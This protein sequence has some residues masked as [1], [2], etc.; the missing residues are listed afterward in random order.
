M[1]QPVGNYWIRVFTTTNRHDNASNQFN[2]VLQYEGASNT[3]DPDSVY[4]VGNRILDDSK[5]LVPDDISNLMIPLKSPPEFNITRAVYPSFKLAR[6][7]YKNISCND[8]ETLDKCFING[9][10]YHMSN[11][12]TLLLLKEKKS[13]IHSIDRIELK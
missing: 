13:S 3:S 10:R 1:S 4:E 7:E 6:I 12:P 11:K 9:I 8:K 5:P 2:A